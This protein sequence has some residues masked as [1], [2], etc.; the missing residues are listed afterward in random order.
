MRGLLSL[1]RGL[2]T[3]SHR[4]ARKARIVASRCD[5]CGTLASSKVRSER[6]PL[7]DRR[8]Q[9]LGLLLLPR[10]ALGRASTP[11][12]ACNFVR[13]GCSGKEEGATRHLTSGTASWCSLLW[14]PSMRE[15]GEKYRVPNCG[16]FVLVPTQ[17]ITSRKKNK[18]RGPCIFCLNWCRI[19]ATS[20]NYVP[21][22]PS[23]AA[24][25]WITV[26]APYVVNIKKRL[27][28]PRT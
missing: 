27:L 17:K 6:L 24:P 11:T 9:L 2:Y 1:H 7:L 10:T 3:L 13:C 12:F 14:S 28:A 16:L 20:T 18:Q 21:V 8:R 5:F 4:Q 22:L 19:I 15:G 26:V 23:L 25:S